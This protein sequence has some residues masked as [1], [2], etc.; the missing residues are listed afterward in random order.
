MSEALDLSAIS[1]YTQDTHNNS[2]IFGSVVANNLIA[3]PT[4][5]QNSSEVTLSIGST[6]DIK[7][8]V[9][10]DP[11]AA[12]VSKQTNS[13]N[14]VFEAN[15]TLELKGGD[16]N[17]TVKISDLS[18]SYNAASNQ[19][20]FTAGD[21]GE[22][23][24]RIM[25]DSS[26]VETS[27]SMQVSG[28][29]LTNGHVISRSLNVGHVED[30]V[31][32]VGYGFRIRDDE[33]L[34]LYKYDNTVGSG[35]TQRIALFG[36][37]Q[38]DANDAFSNFPVFGQQTYQPNDQLILGVNSNTF[39]LWEST[40]AHVF[41]D[42]GRVVIGSSNYTTGLNNVDLEVDGKTFLHNDLVMNNGVTLT[43]SNIT[44]V[45]NITFPTTAFEGTLSTL[46]L[47]SI[48]TNS[49]WLKND[50][51]SIS[52]SAFNNDLSLSAFAS[53]SWFDAAQN[54]ILLSSFSND[55]T[56]Q[57]DM[58]LSQVN[59]S[60]ITFLASGCNF[61]GA[62]TELTGVADF[63]LTA[64]SNDLS[65]V[66]ALHVNA[67][68]TTNVGSDLIPSTD[69]TYS[70]GTSNAR[71][72][73][74]YFGSNSVY[75]G[76]AHIHVID[77]NLVSSK[78]FKTDQIVF[79]D[80]TSMNT[81][82]S[83]EDIQQGGPLGD[84]NAISGGQ[85]SASTTFKIS[86]SYNYGTLYDT[87]SISSSQKYKWVII[88]IN[89]KIHS[90][91]SERHNILRPSPTGKFAF[92][93]FTNNSLSEQMYSGNNTSAINVSFYDEGEEMSNT[94][95]FAPE[96][97]KSVND[98]FPLRTLD[99]SSDKFKNK[100]KIDFDYYNNNRRYNNP[101]NRPVSKLWGYYGGEIV[102]D[103]FSQLSHKALHSDFTKLY[104]IDFIYYYCVP[105]YKNTS[106]QD[107]YIRYIPN[108]ISNRLSGIY[109]RTSN[110]SGVSYVV[111]SIDNL[112]P[113]ITY[114]SW[115]N[116]VEDTKFEIC[117]YETGL[118][119]TSD[120]SDPSNNDSTKTQ[121][122]AKYGSAGNNW[123]CTLLELTFSYIKYG[124][125]SVLSDA[126]KV[127]TDAKY[128]SV[129]VHDLQVT[130]HTLS[131]SSYYNTVMFKPSIF[132]ITNNV[133]TFA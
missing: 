119:W 103:K 19:S 71:F 127:I 88:N 113:R 98:C 27:G 108:T 25:L 42:N 14:V 105:L 104:V 121:L 35:S 46:T 128:S 89:N 57:T 23:N 24:T 126:D 55:I 36:Q 125:I 101:D 90:S 86:G 1:A 100:F 64:F 115:D 109:K 67:F 58:T 78:P 12:S 87:S 22:S 11:T 131:S 81:K 76:D 74:A 91:Q 4:T 75:I 107:N 129:S 56:S 53:H 20:I 10:G 52:L 37:G 124:D 93:T 95:I 60:N 8:V 18:F 112:F 132:D 96:H 70:L 17:N 102:Y 51:S 79:S 3:L 117:E 80:G 114:R 49:T 73:K 130:S 32:K 77:D 106:L 97:M 45:Q 59:T 34:E 133:V 41:Y 66:D 48:P 2:A 110:S 9:D 6:G 63:P 15:D 118:G 33:A 13:S 65:N 69:N 84:F 62:I 72:Q 30:N 31:I 83:S 16:V 43:S 122:L 54:T 85:A 68:T 94:L 82:V 120:N 7:F 39:N 50:Q 47:D 40:G 92:S 61:T 99:P 5:S 26:E 21:L 38:V 29:F 111:S 116:S 123:L 44:N 28:D